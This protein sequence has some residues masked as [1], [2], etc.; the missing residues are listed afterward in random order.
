MKPKRDDFNANFLRVLR[1]EKGLTQIE[2]ADEIGVDRRTVQYWEAG[3]KAPELAQREK[4]CEFFDI[5][6]FELLNDAAQ[7]AYGN[8]SVALLRNKDIPVHV[9]TDTYIKLK[10]VFTA[11][12]DE[13]DNNHPLAGVIGRKRDG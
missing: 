3:E 11:P 2:L 12:T 9:L 6:S 4:L 13:D 1:Q 5:P 8:L 7:I 10:G